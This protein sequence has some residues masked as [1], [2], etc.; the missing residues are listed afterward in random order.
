MD[1]LDAMRAFVAV[2]GR[3]SFAEAARHLRLSPTAVTR[4]VAQ[5]GDELGL[6]LLIRSTRRVRLSEPGGLYLEDCRRILADLDEA[7]RRVRGEAATPRGRLTV[8]APLMFGRL[9]VLP[10]VQRL[11]QAHPDLSVRLMLSDRVV[12]LVEEGVD[13]AVRLA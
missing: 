8:A 6:M 9:R 11:L 5:L 13:V 10:V 7:D 12:H 2:A 1:R 3:R 4:A